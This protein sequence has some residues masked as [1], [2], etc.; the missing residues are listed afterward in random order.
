MTIPKLPKPKVLDPES[1]DVQNQAFLLS[2]ENATRAEI[3]LMRLEVQA[4]K[5][6]G[7][8]KKQFQALAEERAPGV[9]A[10]RAAADHFKRKARELKSSEEGWSNPAEGQQDAVFRQVIGQ[11]ELDM[12]QTA[13]QAEALEAVLGDEKVPQYVREATQAQYEAMCAV[14]L[15]RKAE[16]KALLDEART[17]GIEV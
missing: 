4:S 1:A 10:L 16:H 12:Q 9:K 2:E 11:I 5:A 3:E 15:L 14:I 13:A 17:R 7:E 8:E 6:T